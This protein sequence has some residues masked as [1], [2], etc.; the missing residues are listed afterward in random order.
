MNADDR[1]YRRSSRLL[2]ATLLS[3]SAAFGAEMLT[4]FR[5]ASIQSEFGV[6][7]Q[8][9]FSTGLVELEP[10]SLAHHLAQ[11]MKDVQFSEPVWVIGYRTEILDAQGKPTSG[12][13]LC[14]T[15]F[16]DQRV[17]QRQDQ[18]M[19]AI[20][21]DA[22][23]PEVRLPEGFGIRL[24]LDDPLHWMPMF[25]NREDRPV[26]VAMKVV[27]TV[28]REKDRKKPLEPLY[29]TLRSVQVPHLFFV[30]PG[31]DER[32]VTFEMPFDGRLH[33]LGTHIHPYGSSVELFNI[34][35]RELVWKSSRKAPPDGPMAA[36]SSAAGYPVRAG[37]T[38]R[39]TTVYENTTRDP[40]DAMAG[41]F[42]FYS[43]Q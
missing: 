6:V 19:R 24:T 4:D 30:Q 5:P 39:L 3:C 17:V 32:Q 25:N 7:S 13:Y 18:E 40:V 12:N 1:R 29:S 15:F 8:V 10:G 28:I 2:A 36:Y 14:H 31:R 43:R 16:G 41:L 27:L 38:Y 34:T 33:F 20:Y 22:F 26:R 11:A 37:E 21:S 23:T 42:L 35:R 9:E